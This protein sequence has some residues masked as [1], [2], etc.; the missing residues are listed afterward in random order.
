MKRFSVLALSLSAVF[1]FG[2]AGRATDRSSQFGGA[3]T[4]S[5]PPLTQA[6]LTG[7]SSEPPRILESYPPEY[8]T[9]AKEWKLDGTVILTITIDE[10]GTVSDAEV[11]STTNPVFNDAALD[12]VKRYKFMPAKM[13]GQPVSVVIDLPISFMLK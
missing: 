2:C 3:Q 4:A 10:S 9:D 7:P 12:A 11:K 8:P 1:V 13:D 6:E 5:N